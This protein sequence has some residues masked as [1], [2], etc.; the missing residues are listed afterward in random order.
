MIFAEPKFRCMELQCST[1]TS[2]LVARRDQ[3]TRDFQS[4]QSRRCEVDSK[5]RRTLLVYHRNC[6]SLA[7]TAGIEQGIVSC[8]RARTFR[9]KVVIRKLIIGDSVETGRIVGRP[10]DIQTENIC[11]NSSYNISNACC[12]PHSNKILVYSHMCIDLTTLSRAVVRNL[13][14]KL[15]RFAIPVVRSVFVRK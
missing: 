9:R 10:T 12:V 11:T 6:N 15:M 5:R 2:K 14:T 3:D 13:C 8:H 4:C 1:D 7:A